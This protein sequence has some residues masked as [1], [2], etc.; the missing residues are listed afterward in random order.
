[1]EVGGKINGLRPTDIATNAE[2]I[3]R[4]PFLNKLLD[5]LDINATASEN[6]DLLEASH[7]QP[8][9]DLPDQSGGDPSPLRW[10]IK[11][12][13]GELLAQS[14]S[15]QHRFLRLIPKGINQGNAGD[16]CRHMLIEG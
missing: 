6:L 2:A 12:H 11:T 5:A 10:G 9:S 13:A 3:N 8:S 16:T 7:I 14:L 15:H 1:M 4:R